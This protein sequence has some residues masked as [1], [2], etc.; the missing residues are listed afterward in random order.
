MKS[1]KNERLVICLGFILLLGVM[2]PVAAA[3]SASAVNAS[4]NTAVNSGIDFSIR[5]FDRR[6]YYA[7][8]DAIKIQVTITNN[9]PLTYRFKLA[10]E[11]V[12][13]P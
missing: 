9:S 8:S 6:V 13:S 1:A 10:D 4:A 7:Q 3:D 2:M 11:R 12:F 5:F